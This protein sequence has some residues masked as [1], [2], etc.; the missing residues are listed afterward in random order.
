MDNDL[1]ELQK[2]IAGLESKIN[3]DNMNYSGSTLS[4]RQRLPENQS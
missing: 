4:A 2:R 1:V 3:L